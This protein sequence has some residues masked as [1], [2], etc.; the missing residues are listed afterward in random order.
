[1]PY[2]SWLFFTHYHLHWDWWVVPV[3]KRRR[4]GSLPV[5]TE[6]DLK[7][8]YRP[9]IGCLITPVSATAQV[10]DRRRLFI[11][12]EVSCVHCHY[13]FPVC[14]STLNT[15]SN[16]LLLLFTSALVGMHTSWVPDN[17]SKQLHLN[18]PINELCFKELIRY[19]CFKDNYYNC[20]NFSPQFR[21]L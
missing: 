11:I 21:G 14:I 1:M 17:L 20:R 2:P 12:A 8:D 16:F 15:N 10:A 5:R 4:L 7:C 13:W 9:H 3:I 18:V 6:R 19:N